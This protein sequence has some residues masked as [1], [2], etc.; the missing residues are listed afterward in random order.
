MTN[1]LKLQ[2]IQ[3]ARGI[4]ALAVVAYHLSITLAEPR[5]LND[6]VFS[7][8]THRGNLGV[9]FFFVLSGFIIMHAH[10]GDVG[11]GLDRWK[12]YIRARF[13]RMF[14]IYWL[15]T[16][17]ICALLIVGLGTSA[18]AP[19]GLIQWLSTFS[20]VRL[21]NFGT[22]I[23]PA[24]TLFHEVAFYAVFSVLI[25]NRRA[26][27]FLFSLWVALILGHFQYAPAANRTPFSTYF[28]AYNLDFLL[29][30]LAQ[31]VVRKRFKLSPIACLLGV[32]LFG[33][34]YATESGGLFVPL[35]YASSFALIIVGLA[36]AE[37]VRGGYSLP[38]GALV[39]N[40]S[41]TIYLTHQA[42]EG[43]F[44]K[45]LSHVSIPHAVIFITVFLLSVA[46]GVL[47]YLL[48]EKPLMGFLKQT[49]MR[50]TRRTVSALNLIPEEK[51]IAA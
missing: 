29:G 17:G 32:A 2:S 16:A 18:K 1:P 48:V 26:G 20:L 27:L 23:A 43:V 46:A 15:Y 21:E 3:A 5:Y 11:K 13:T 7:R 39:G 33:L 50:R 36:S 44:A 37:T 34:L 10:G 9:D 35:G 47:S 6:A 25:I 38:L 31:F 22:P 49:L 19:V 42:F 41:Y 24:W 28:S 8:F 4:A 45:V 30:M 51:E 12:H 40:A 14:P